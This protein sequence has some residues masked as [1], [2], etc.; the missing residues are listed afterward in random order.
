MGKNKNNTNER[1]YKEPGEGTDQKNI[2]IDI[3]GIVT[4]REGN[5]SRERTKNGMTSKPCIVISIAT[6][7]E[8]DRTR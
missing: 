1:R 5:L 7:M 2:I 3:P 8:A 4:E 6:E